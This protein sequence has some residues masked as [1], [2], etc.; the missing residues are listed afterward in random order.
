MV[1]FLYSL[2]AETFSITVELGLGFYHVIY[3]SGRS[4]D[5]QKGGGGEVNGC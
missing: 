3:N 1:N 5:F 4:Q 2:I